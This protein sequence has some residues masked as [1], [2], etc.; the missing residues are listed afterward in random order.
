MAVLS[1][2]PFPWHK[3]CLLM[4]ETHRTRWSS[5]SLTAKGLILLS[6]PLCLQ[7]GF[8]VVLIGLQQEAEADAQ[9]AIEARSIAVERNKLMSEILE[10]FSFSLG[11]PKL[12]WQVDGYRGLMAPHY[13][14]LLGR[15]RK[16]YKGLEYLTRDKPKLN[17]VVISSNLSFNQAVEMVEQSNSDI[18]AGNMDR[19]MATSKEKADRF[20]ALAKDFVSPELL[21][22]A[23]NEDGLANMST[24]KQAEIRQTT[25]TCAFMLILATVI[26]S[27][28]LAKL[29]VQ[30]IT[31]RLKIMA[32]NTVRFAAHQPLNPPLRGEDEIAELDQLFHSMAYTIEESAQ[33]KQEIYNMVTDE[34]QTPLT[35]IHGCLEILE[36]GQMEKF[37]DRSKKLINV[38]MRNSSRTISLVNDLL[39]SQKIEAGMLELNTNSVRLGDVFDNVN[40][41]ISG[42]I[43]ENGLQISFA[44]TA[45]AVDVNQDMLSRILFNL[46][47]N[48]IKYS[49]RGGTIAVNAAP[50]STMAEITV[51]DQ[52]P[53][54]PEDML[55]AVFD[56]FRQVSGNDP[57]ARGGSGLG[58][59]ICRDFVHLHGGEIWVSSQVGHGS[60]FHFT[61]PL[62]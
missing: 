37:S 44:S 13:S 2:S 26:F 55:K 49:P 54:I 58:L 34:V 4:P 57:V 6:I 27:A 42:W 35:A 45:L 46:I 36:L 11:E 19:V 38:A 21:V 7:L 10:L 60:I 20:A 5:L 25:V 24:R 40:Q 62:S 41:D 23:M 33:A 29:L 1:I 15:I 51:S 8:G 43:E 47:S 14:E 9:R 22:A 59:S 28:V 30:T 61:L 16:D 32:D 53:G 52:G 17:R 39:D 31:S 12:H 3:D 56:R 48:A 18:L 50:I